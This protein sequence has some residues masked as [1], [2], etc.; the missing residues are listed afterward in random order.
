MTAPSPDDD[1][2]DDDDG[3]FTRND[4]GGAGG[5]FFEYDDE[6]GGGGGGGGAPELTRP[7]DF[8][9]ELIRKREAKERTWWTYVM[10]R[11]GIL[12]HNYD[13]YSRRTRAVWN[14]FTG[15]HGVLAAVLLL[16]GTFVGVALSSRTLENGRELSHIAQ[17]AMRKASKEC[18]VYAYFDAAGTDG[19]AVF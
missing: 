10:T 7:N 15:C 14:E 8:P 3:F 13:A 12:R 5:G 11:A 9:T 16:T 19:G 1:D 2:D 18:R 4:D 6:V 17:D